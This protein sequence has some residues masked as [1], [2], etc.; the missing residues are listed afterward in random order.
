MKEKLKFKIAM[1]TYR[2]WH[3]LVFMVLSHCYRKNVIDSNQLHEILA[4]LD[5]TQEHFALEKASKHSLA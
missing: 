2:A 5:R 1:I 4:K 3:P